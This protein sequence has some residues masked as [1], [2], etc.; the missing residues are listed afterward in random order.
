MALA[1]TKIIAL[2]NRWANFLLT[3]VIL[4]IFNLHSDTLFPSCQIIHTYPLQNLLVWYLRLNPGL[5]QTAREYWYVIWRHILVDIIDGYYDTEFKFFTLIWMALSLWLGHLCS[6]NSLFC[7]V[8]LI[9]NW[10]ELILIVFKTFS[11][12]LTL[13]NSNVIL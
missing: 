4:D 12:Y 10:K 13:F 8:F 1:G 3:S 5:L 2:I 7:F 11:I 6:P 9:F